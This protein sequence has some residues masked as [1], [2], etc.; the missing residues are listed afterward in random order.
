MPL[1]DRLH[2]LAHPFKASPGLF[3]PFF[4]DGK[5]LQLAADE[6]LRQSSEPGNNVRFQMRN[7]VQILSQQFREERRH[8][9]D[10]ENITNLQ[11]ASPIVEFL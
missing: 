5:F 7:A 6:P 10:I 1:W 9:V 4:G 3:S 2:Y 8:H 11:Q